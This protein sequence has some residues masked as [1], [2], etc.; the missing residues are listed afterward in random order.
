MKYA[1]ILDTADE[2]KKYAQAT[3]DELGETCSLL[4]QLSG[5]PSYL[6]ENFYDVLCHEIEGQLLNFKTHSRIVEKSEMVE[7]K[8]KQIEWEGI[9]Y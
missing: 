9:D 6:S 4:I 5:Y 2:L 1:E 7:Q 8:W 3:G